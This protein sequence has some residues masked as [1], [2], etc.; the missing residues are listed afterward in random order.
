ME[1]EKTKDEAG[2]PVSFTVS[3][4]WIGQSG[5]VV[6]ND[7]NRRILEEIQRF[8]RG[9]VAGRSLRVGVKAGPARSG[10][11]GVQEPRDISSDHE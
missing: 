9:A 5:T 4:S 2:D 6:A 3:V 1:R 11:V 10:F 8:V 7:R